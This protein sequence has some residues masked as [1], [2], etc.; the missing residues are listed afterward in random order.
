MTCS[1]ILSG[2]RCDHAADLHIKVN[3]RMAWLCG[4]CI[5]EVAWAR[6]S[7]GPVRTFTSHHIGPACGVSGSRWTDDGCVWDGI[8][9]D[10]IVEEERQTVPT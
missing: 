10:A 9:V 2:R 7:C 8:D 5:P 4:C 6:T 3:G 1:M